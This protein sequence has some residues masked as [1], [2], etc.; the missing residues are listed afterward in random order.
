MK[1]IARSFVAASALVWSV[2]ALAAGHYVPGVEGIQA[3]SVP[4]PGIYYLG[5][6]VN[7]NI[8]GINGAPGHNTGTVSVLANRGVWITPY[9]VMGADYGIET[10]VPIQSNSF[11]FTGLGY[12]GTTRGVGDV[13]IGPIV[14]GWHGNQW[15]AVFSLGEWLDNASYSATNPSSVGLGYK[16]TML[17]L[18]GTYYPDTKK[19]WSISALARFE[20]N[21]TQ[22]QTG[23]KPGNGLSIEWGIGRQI[24]GGKQVG[25]VGYYQDQTSN[26]SG[27]GAPTQNP[28]KSAIGVQFDYPILER[29]LFLKFA[30]YHEYAVS[31]APRGNM[32][33]MTIVKAF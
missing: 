9:K 3:A 14:L 20:K 11:T 4:P 10:I 16:S 22:S 15:D 24:G 2:G 25:L 30:A 13:Y 21:G 8:T 18:G 23:I 27:P 6:L 17:T 31:N 1:K 29:G 32:L 12:S 26:S 28:H 7:Y 19:E 5:Y 33:R